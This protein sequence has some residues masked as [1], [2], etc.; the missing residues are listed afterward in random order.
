MFQRCV[1]T[2]LEYCFLI[3]DK[4]RKEEQEQQQRKKKKKK[5][6][7]LQAAF[8]AHNISSSSCRLLP[9]LNNHLS[10]RDS[11][12]WTYRHTKYSWTLEISN[13][14]SLSSQSSYPTKQVHQFPSTFDVH[15]FPPPKSTRHFDTSQA[16]VPLRG[17]LGNDKLEENRF[18]AI[19]PFRKKSFYDCHWKT[20]SNGV[21]RL[22]SH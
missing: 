5:L 6:L 7:H 17:Q 3:I 13:Q 22:W 1:E 8:S 12:S 18:V 2:T 16:T 20:C 14:R 9:S 15:Q 4:I 11:P 19:Q 21:Q 10:A